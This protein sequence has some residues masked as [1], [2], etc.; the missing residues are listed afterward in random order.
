M[1]LATIMPPPEV[2]H[3]LSYKIP[4]GFPETLIY[5]GAVFDFEELNPEEKSEFRTNLRKGIKEAQISDFFKN[6]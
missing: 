1:N 6:N 4:D 2:Y 5:K 3:T